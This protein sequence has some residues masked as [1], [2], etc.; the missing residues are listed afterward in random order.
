[1][2]CFDGNLS[3]PCFVTAALGFILN[4]YYISRGEEA[5]GKIQIYTERVWLV[6]TISGLVAGCAQEE[7]ARNDRPSRYEPSEKSEIQPRSSR[8]K[9]RYS[10]ELR[11]SH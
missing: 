4:G 11:W 10:S 7:P 2:L 8:R 3:L 5:S 1:M 9:S 6:F